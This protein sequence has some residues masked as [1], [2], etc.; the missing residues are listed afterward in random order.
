MEDKQF[1]PDDGG[2]LVEAMDAASSFHSRRSK[3]SKKSNSTVS[4]LLSNKSLDLVFG[5]IDDYYQHGP[6]AQLHSTA[7]LI[8]NIGPSADLLGNLGPSSSS[9]SSSLSALAAAADVHG[10]SVDVIRRALSVADTDGRRLYELYDLLSTAQANSA[11]VGFSREHLQ[12]R[13]MSCLRTRHMPHMCNMYAHGHGHGA[14]C[15]RPTVQRARPR[16]PRNPCVH[17]DGALLVPTQRLDAELGE[18][19]NLLAELTSIER[20]FSVD[21]RS[22]ELAP[23]LAALAHWQ[24]C[25]L[26]NALVARMRMHT[27]AGP[28]VATAVSAACPLPTASQ[29]IAQARPQRPSVLPVAA[30]PYSS[31]PQPLLPVSL[32]SVVPFAASTSAQSPPLPAQPRPMFAPVHAYSR[33]GFIAPRQFSM[34]QKIEMHGGGADAHDA[35]PPSQRRKKK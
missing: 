22:S 23:K 12:V 5:L 20:G 1:S 30:C 15:V 21:A 4:S 25:V 34:D 26:S 17:M 32:T 16:R 14:T 3:S 13:I 28:N 24:E 35:H 9:D 33:A 7:D 10:Q 8:G 29:Y 11:N 31:H 27:G 18:I 6:P 2:G 19:R